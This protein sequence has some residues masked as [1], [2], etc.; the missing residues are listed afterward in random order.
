MF[1]EKLAANIDVIKN[2][3][4]PEINL[5]DGAEFFFKILQNKYSKGVLANSLEEFVKSSGKMLKTKS[6]RYLKDILYKFVEH[7]LSTK[8][9]IGG[10]VLKNFSE[11][12]GK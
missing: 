6:A 12:T 3:A 11:F 8:A 10:V 1:L 9:I 2:V 7:F 5:N 4:R